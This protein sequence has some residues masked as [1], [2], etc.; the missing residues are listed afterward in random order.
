M[1]KKPISKNEL[2]RYDRQII[3]SNWGLDGQL[4]LKNSTVIVIGAGGLGSTVLLYLAAAGIGNIRIIDNDIL[5]LSNLNR[6]VLYNEDDINK[7][8]ALL[9]Q[10]KLSKLNKDIRIV[11]INETLD[12]K[13]ADKLLNGADLIVDCLDNFKTRFL[14]NRYCI[15]NKIP[16]VHGA[17]YGLE[18]RVMFI[19]PKNEESPCLNCFYPE[20]IPPMGKF[21]VLGSV[22]GITASIE[23]TEAIKYLTKI[24]KNLIG[25]FLVID[26]RLMKFKSIIIK[27]NPKC[28]TCGVN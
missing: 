25:E 18:G 12:E 8:K 14:V 10:M 11:G 16:F 20:D 1:E 13:S 27:K 26:G 21:P 5:E 6:Q 24:G 23:A 7:P 19:D 28:K 22:V 15:N 4:R 2:E 17:I 3:I 9:A